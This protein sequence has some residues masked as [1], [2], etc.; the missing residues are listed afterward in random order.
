MNNELWTP[1]KTV[2]VAGKYSADTEAARV[3]N[4][5]TA[6]GYARRIMKMGYTPF[7]PHTSH[8]IDPQNDQF[9]YEAWMDWCLFWLKKCDILLVTSLSKGVRIE[10]DC[11]VKNAIPIVWS[12]DQLEWRHEQEQNRASVQGRQTEPEGPGFRHPWF[13]STGAALQAAPNQ[14]AGE[15]A[16]KAAPEVKGPSIFVPPTFTREA[17]G[18]A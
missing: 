3:A 15:Q 13:D 6:C 7:V 14:T 2:Y 5:H 17:K 8:F 4:V 16:A 10:I 11:A 12:V 1:G 18:F 9:P